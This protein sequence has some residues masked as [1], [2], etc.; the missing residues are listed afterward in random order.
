MSSDHEWNSDALLEKALLYGSRA[1]ESA[2]DSSLYGFWSSLSLELLARA[3]LAKVHPVLLADPR[4][5]MN[6]LSVFGVPMEKGAPISIP[7]KTLYSRC[8]ALIPNFDEAAQKHCMF[9]ALIRNKE[10]HSGEAAFEAITHNRWQ[11]E[12]YRVVKLLC[13]FLGTDGGV[14][15]PEEEAEA[16]EEI[17]SDTSKELEGRADNK[18]K[19]NK[20]WFNGLSDDEKERLRA[21]ADNHVDTVV[22]AHRYS[23]ACNCPACA[24]SGVIAG[25][26]VQNMKVS[27]EEGALIQTASVSTA[28][29]YCGTCKLDLNRAELSAVGL[30]ASMIVKEEID[31]IDHF[32]VDPRDYFDIYDLDPSEAAEY[33]ERHGFYLSEPDYGND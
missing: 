21:D 24:S 22:N 3:A 16:I 20:D 18:V 30:P 4:D 8:L 25:D 15:F 1:V 31:P 19:T 28:R 33:A 27:L 6:I 14:F 32:G 2:R 11:P 10:L 17:I 13:E 12:Q 26:R 9:I 7:A 5:G 29:Y 23:Q